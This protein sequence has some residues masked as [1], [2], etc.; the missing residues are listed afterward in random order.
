M[1]KLKREAKFKW[2]PFIQATKAINF[3]FAFA[4]TH[5][6]GVNG[7]IYVIFVEGTRAVVDEIDRVYEMA[8]L[9]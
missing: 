3:S 5:A 2:L 7:L 4:L 8:N 6:R 1:Q 9:L